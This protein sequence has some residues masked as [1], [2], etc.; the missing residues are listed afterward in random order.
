MKQH[1]QLL[2]EVASARPDHQQGH[3]PPLD[4]MIEA[5]VAILDCIRVVCLK[6]RDCVAQDIAY[7]R[8]GRGVCRA[9]GPAKIGDVRSGP[10]HT[11]GAGPE[12]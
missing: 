4:P 1:V 5:F 10:N 3:E 12:T 9:A 8:V 7:V 2:S 11:P 6:V